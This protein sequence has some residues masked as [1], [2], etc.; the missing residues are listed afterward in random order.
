LKLENETGKIKASHPAGR[1]A[2]FHKEEFPREKGACSVRVAGLS[3]HNVASCAISNTA[4]GGSGA[5]F[6]P[7][8][9]LDVPMSQEALTQSNWGSKI[10]NPGLSSSNS[11]STDT[12]EFQGTHTMAAWVIQQVSLQTD[13][14]FPDK[15]RIQE[16]IQ[17]KRATN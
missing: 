6:T 14:R 4:W 7:T 12:H 1:Q 15:I 17:R 16:R 2:L 5:A 8:A 3:I 9:C 10:R 11:T 13:N